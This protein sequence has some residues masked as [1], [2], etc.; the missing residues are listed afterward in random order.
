[1]AS[2]SSALASG[3]LGPLLGQF[4]LPQAAIDAA[5]KGGRKRKIFFWDVNLW[6]FLDVEEFAKAMQENSEKKEEAVTE[7]DEKMNVD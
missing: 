2:F 4:G 7:E 5:N 3:Q 6:W 1:M